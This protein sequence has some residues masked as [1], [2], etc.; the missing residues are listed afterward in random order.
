METGKSELVYDY[1]Y[2]SLAGALDAYAKNSV[3]RNDCGCAGVMAG[4]PDEQWH[5][6]LWLLHCLLCVRVER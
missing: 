4:M 2:D 3:Y 6:L 5:D 1:A